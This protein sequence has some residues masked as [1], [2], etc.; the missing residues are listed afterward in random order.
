MAAKKSARKPGAR[1]GARFTSEELAAMKE[2]ARELRSRA[3]AGATTGEAEVL[4][5][6]ATMAPGDRDL[7]ERLHALVRAHAPDLSA[8]TWYGMPAYSKNGQILCFFQAAGKFK[9]RYATLGFSDEA[10]LDEDK[11]WPTA[12]ALTALS[13]AEE[14]RIAALLKRA[15]T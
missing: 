2:R 9:T 8:R 10:N 6:I 12:F 3:P 5:K 4:A 7:A 14:A 1:S 15:L 11:M 13:P